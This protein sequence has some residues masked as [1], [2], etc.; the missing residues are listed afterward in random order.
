MPLTTAPT[1]RRCLG[2]TPTNPACQ[3]TVAE[4]ARCIDALRA[5][6]C[7]ETFIFGAECADVTTFDCL[8][9]TPSAMGIVRVREQS[10]DPLG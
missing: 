8:V 2:M 9:F 10:G 3:A 1:R 7:E 4:Y 6:P 5:S